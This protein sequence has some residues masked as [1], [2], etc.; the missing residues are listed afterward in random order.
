[1]L[2]FLAANGRPPTK[3]ER[4]ERF[5]WGSGG[6]NQTA[7]ALE[8]RGLL[9]TTGR[10]VAGARATDAGRELAA[11]LRGPQHE[12]SPRGDACG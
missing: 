2:A 9:E 11:A 1:M 3:D 7:A 12:P 8:R 6:F 4:R 10:Y 5:N